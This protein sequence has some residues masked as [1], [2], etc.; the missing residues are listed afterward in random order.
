MRAEPE[1]AAATLRQ[2]EHQLYSI[3][4]VVPKNAL[5]RL[6]E[7][8][9][10]VS[11][12]SGTLCMAYH[13]SAGWLRDH[14]FDPAMAKAVEL[15]NPAAFLSWTKAQPWMV[16]HELAHAYHD[17]VLGFDHAAIRAA[18][19]RARADEAWQVV[20]HA[21]GREVS[22]YALTNHK[23]FFAEISEAWFGTNDMYPFVR[24]ELQRH[25]AKS[26]ELLKRLWR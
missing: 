15:G 24:A 22:P 26:A 7:V 1:L 9:I 23:E 8:P 10:W 11:R 14:G 19:R 2:V 3:N 5:A 21:N 18:H 25:D 16:M 13:P 12:R 4:R 6:R 20:L 17:R